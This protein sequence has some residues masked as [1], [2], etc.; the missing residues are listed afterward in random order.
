MVGDKLKWTRGAFS[1]GNLFA[2][3]GVGN[4]IGFGLYHLMEKE[5]YN[6]YF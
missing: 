5:N 2:L 4:I 1:G 3:F 6:Y